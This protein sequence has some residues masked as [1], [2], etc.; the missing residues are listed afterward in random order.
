MVFGMVAIDE[1]RVT[2]E[3]KETV[4]RGRVKT[5][6][7]F[8]FFI[9]KKYVLFSEYFIITNKKRIYFLIIESIRYDFFP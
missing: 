6:Y 3:E 8:S 2:L 9:Y 4:M 7:L 5:C 1:I